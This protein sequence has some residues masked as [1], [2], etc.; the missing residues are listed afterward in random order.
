MLDLLLASHVWST[1][2][3]K[4]RLNSGQIQ[5]APWVFQPM[6]VWGQPSSLKKQRI[7]TWCA[8]QI[9]HKP[10]TPLSF[11]N[12]ETRSARNNLGVEI[13]PQRRVKNGLTLQCVL[14][15]LSIQKVH[16]SYILLSSYY[17]IPQSTKSSSKIQTSL[18]CHF[19]QP[20]ILLSIQPN[21][22]IL[23]V[24]TCH[25]VKRIMVSCV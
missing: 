7:L 3:T 25:L 10:Q 1:S 15:F 11:R 5:L 16:K 13:R 20:A 18:N 22:K 2:P 21:K 14:Q 19:P 12:P 23:K 9:W 4:R 24:V 17:I 8:K 6:M